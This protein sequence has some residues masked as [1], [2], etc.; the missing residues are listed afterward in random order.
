MKS[1][2][3]FTLLFTAIVCKAQLSELNT[4]VGAMVVLDP[5]SISVGDNAKKRGY[6]VGPHVLGD[7]ITMLMNKFQNDY[8]YYESTGGAYNVEEK[9]IIKPSIYRAILKVNKH[10]EKA[11][12]KGNITE[13]NAYGRMKSILRKGIELK[14][15]Y[16]EDVEVQLKKLKKAEDIER[17]LDTIKFRKESLN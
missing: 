8:V 9:K 7:T 11:V 14:N 13:G 3:V 17:Y 4:R 16:T 10:Y 12:S 2:F 5:T 6:Y 1:I 15:Y